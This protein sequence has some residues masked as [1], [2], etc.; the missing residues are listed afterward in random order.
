MNDNPWYVD[1]M[2]RQARERI[3]EDMRQ[4]RLEQ[5]ALEGRPRAPASGASRIVGLLVALGAAATLL[6]VI[7]TGRL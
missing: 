2:S 4:A 5:D 7:L 1:Q 6:Q 3:R